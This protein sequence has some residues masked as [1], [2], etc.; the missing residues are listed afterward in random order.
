MPVLL[1]FGAVAEI[2]GSKKEELDAATL[3]EL[4]EAANLRFGERFEKALR[5]CTLAIDGETIDEIDPSISVEEDSEVAILPPVSGGSSEPERRGQRIRMADVSSKPITHRVATARCRISASQ[6][7]LDA[8]ASGELP[9]G[10][11][12][13]A[14]E[15][16]A[17]I[18]AKKTPDLVPLCHPITISSVDVDI[19]RDGPR[20]LL[21]SVTVEGDDKT[22]YEMEAMAGAAAAALTIYDMAKSQE[23]GI[24][25]ED[26]RLVSKSGGKSGDWS[27]DE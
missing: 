18:G 26:L 1:M 8:V 13:A 3:G 10:D 27:L 7:T 14:A 6:E 16:A 11:A 9:K 25:I 21:I 20:S 23:P 22:G 24:A 5:H 2:A 12:I 17:V 4:L 19:A 15:L